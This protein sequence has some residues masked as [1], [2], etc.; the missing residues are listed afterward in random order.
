MTAVVELEARTERAGRNSL[1]KSVISN[2]GQQKSV[3]FKVFDNC[4]KENKY[5]FFLNS[6]H[7]FSFNRQIAADN[8]LDYVI[9]LNV[10][11]CG[12]GDIYIYIIFV[13]IWPI[14]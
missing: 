14:M 5:G 9:F 6:K 8:L 4:N 7:L 10:R 3:I 2:F 1:M 13:W 11:V 12:T